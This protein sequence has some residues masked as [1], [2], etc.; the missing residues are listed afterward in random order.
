MDEIEAIF[1]ETDVIKE[2]I[3]KEELEIEA[4]ETD[5]DVLLDSCGIL[6]TSPSHVLNTL[7]QTKKSKSL[8]MM[9]QLEP[10]THKQKAGHG[11]ARPRSPKVPL[12]TVK[13]NVVGASMTR[14]LDFDDFQATKAVL[15][16]SLSGKQIKFGLPTYK[17][18]L[19][20]ETAETSSVSSD[21][22]ADA[23]TK[24]DKAN[25]GAPSIVVSK[26]AN[27][28]ANT[29]DVPN[30]AEPTDSQNAQDSGAEKSSQK[31]ESC[32]AVNGVD[33]AEEH[34]TFAEGESQRKHKQ[35]VA[36][37]HPSMKMSLR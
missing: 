22:D 5:L 34:D 20:L 12:R 21:S 23:N 6:A 4:E 2:M 30:T 37:Y 19:L 26:D 3:E 11:G 36:L 7:V 31:A 16:D 18:M 25:E 28:Q 17:E 29:N 32:E 27:N 1:E 9:H 35:I 8:D 14:S 15:G 24:A 33:A 13:D 10:E